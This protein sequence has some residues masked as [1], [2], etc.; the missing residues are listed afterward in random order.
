MPKEYKLVVSHNGEEELSRMVN[1]LL[2]EGW[3]PQGGV[4]T[5][6]RDGAYN[7]VLIQAMVR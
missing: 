2:A 7:Q 6:L 3:K 5:R 1:A 4:A